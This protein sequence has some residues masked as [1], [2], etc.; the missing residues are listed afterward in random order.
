MRTLVISLA[1]G[2]LVATTATAGDCSPAACCENP[3][4]CDKACKDSCCPRCC[5]DRKTCKVECGV[6]LVKRH[7]WVVE[8][9]EMCPTLPGRDCCR[10]RCCKS[11]DCDKCCENGCGCAKVDPCESLK[12]REYVQPKCMRSRCIKKLVKKEVLCEVPAYKCVP[13][14]AKP[15][16]ACG[17]GEDGGAEE[18][19]PAEG[20]PE[21]APPAPAAPGAETAPEPPV[22]GTAYLEALKLDR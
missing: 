19:T 10:D 3:G 12:N 6:R 1:I 2:L 11:G 14:C 5:S 20:A 17:C 22:V 16:A 4:C 18:A 15:A 9:N 13:V 7:V 21:E 8:C